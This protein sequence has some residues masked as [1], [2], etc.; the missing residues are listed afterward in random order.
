MAI[1]IKVVTA[2]A[3]WEAALRSRSLRLENNDPS[4]GGGTGGG[5]LSPP[6]SSPG[7][8]RRWATEALTAKEEEG[9][10]EGAGKLV[11]DCIEAGRSALSEG[12]RELEALQV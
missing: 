9:G 2:S 4:A 12:S 5:G 7:G 1:A 10:E 8:R 6:P 11:G 3:E